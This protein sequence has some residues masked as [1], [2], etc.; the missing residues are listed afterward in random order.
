MADREILKKILAHNPQNV[1]HRA[2]TVKIEDQHTP[3]EDGT[4]QA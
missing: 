4:D 1:E 3:Q 2:P